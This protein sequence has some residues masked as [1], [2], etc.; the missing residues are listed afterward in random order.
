MVS[1]NKTNI[2]LHCVNGAR[3]AVR[4][5]IYTT[6]DDQNLR[7]NCSNNVNGQLRNENLHTPL[8]NRGKPYRFTTCKWNDVDLGMLHCE[9]RISIQDYI[10][11][12]YGFSFG[13]HCKELVR[14]SFRGLSFNF[15]ISR[16]TNRTRCIKIPKCDKHIFRCRGYYEYTSLPNLIGDLNIQNVSNWMDSNTASAYL[17]LISAIYEQFCHKYLKEFICRIA[18]PECDPE[19]EHVVHIC[20]SNCYEILEACSKSFSSILQLMSS[21][22]VP[23]SQRPRNIKHKVSCDYLPSINSSITCFNKPVT[24]ELPSDAT[25]VKIINRIKPNKAYFAMSQVEYECLDETFQI[26]G[27]STVTCLYSGEWNKTPKCLKKKTG[28]D[29]NPLSIVIPL[30]T[31]SFVIF[32][33]ISIIMKHICQGKKLLKR[34][35]EYD[36]FVCYNFDAD[37]DFLFNSILP[38]LKKNHDPPLKMFIHDRNFT[39]GR[40]ININIYNAIENCNSAIIVMSQGFIN[41]GR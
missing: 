41:S 24:C 20:R 27:N 19:T 25:N 12:H 17:G 3:C 4:L 5:D 16:Q 18:Y 14:P 36:S 31:I 34:N 11:R 32:V 33:I 10:P 40:D 2:A 9:G 23:L 8:Y 7:S 35:R 28:S 38:E 30:L 37:R 22:L 13:Y 15:T 21:G 39:P 6:Q 26:E 1:F 29:V